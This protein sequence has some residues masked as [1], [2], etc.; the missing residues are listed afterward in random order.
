VKRFS[1]CFEGKVQ[2]DE[3]AVEAKMQDER[4]TA[5]AFPAVKRQKDLLKTD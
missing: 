2:T 1:L 4:K 3:K 5:N